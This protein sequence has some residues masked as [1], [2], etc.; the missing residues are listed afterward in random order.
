MKLPNG[1]RARVDVQRKLIGYCLNRSHRTGRHKAQVFESAIGVT[2]QNAELLSDALKAAARDGDA[3]VK[4]RSADATK[5]EIEFTLTGPRGT[6]V[7]R[8]G[9]RHRERY[10]YSALDHLLRQADRRF[11][12]VTLSNF[13]TWWR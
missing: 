2:D 9:W 10:R 4:S 3:R 6:A 7:V 11:P 5:Y 12:C 8:S 13:M 1:E